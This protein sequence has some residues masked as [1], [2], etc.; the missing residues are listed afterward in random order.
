MKD[1]EYNI[2]KKPLMPPV[3]AATPAA[4]LEPQTFEELVFFCL[5]EASVCWSELPR[6]V[7]DSAKAYEIATKIIEWHKR[8]L[9]EVDA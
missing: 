1:H 5:G 9:D 3:E 7:F 2:T 6:G 8:E 4:S